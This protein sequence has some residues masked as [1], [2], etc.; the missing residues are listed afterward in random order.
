VFSAYFRL[1]VLVGV[2]HPSMSG[3]LAMIKPYAVTIV[4]TIT[5]VITVD[6]ESA[7][8]ARQQIENYGIVE[9]SND[10]PQRGELMFPRVTTV[11]LI[12]RGE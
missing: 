12:K 6:A 1:G 2:D 9:A 3:Y 10:Y 11:K 7:S 5:T 4:R 8:A